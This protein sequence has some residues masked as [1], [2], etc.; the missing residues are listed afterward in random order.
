MKPYLKEKSKAKISVVI[1]TYNRR[2]FV[3]QAVE[4]VLAQTF[5]D[6]E[7]VVVDDGSTD[8][9]EQ[10]LAGLGDKIQYIWQ[11]NQGESVARNKGINLAQGEYI[12]LLDSDDLWEP[13]KLSKQTSA[14]INDPNVVM[15]GCASRI[16]NESG[17]FMSNSISG[18]VH[19][20]E[21]LSYGAL[22]YHNHFF[23][24]GSTAMFRRT[25][26]EQIG[27][28]APELRYGEEWDLWLRLAKVGSITVINQPLAR[29]RQ[30]G[31][32]QTQAMSR[33]AIDRRLN[34]YTTILRRNPPIDNNDLDSAMAKQYLRAAVDDISIDRLLLAKERLAESWQ[35][36]HGE[37]IKTEAV[38]MVIAR[39]NA[40]A[41]PT[42]KPT[43]TVLTFFATALACLDA[44]NDQLF[45]SQKESYRR[46]YLSL[47]GMA[48]S[49]KNLKVTRHCLG[50][51]LKHD[52]SAWRHPGFWGGVIESL[53]GAKVFN[54]LRSSV[55][56]NQ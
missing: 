44:V 11:E 10:E 46:L 1:P 13:E 56:G 16:I 40:M 50:L 4:S 30:H 32:T 38:E 43:H 27:G 18:I 35:W 48:R 53:V 19:E 5:L 20:P 47:A 7:I 3:R 41:A 37:V 42:F 8:G 2:V 12:A 34:D 14:L 23:G 6:Y 24:G 33:E 55:K 9:T 15:V 31:A 51:A 21:Q 26:F 49:R 54:W 39:A 45:F 29:I 17:N 22:R 36:D 25:T 52:P 28:F